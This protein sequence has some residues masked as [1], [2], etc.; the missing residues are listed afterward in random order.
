MVFRTR[1]VEMPKTIPEYSNSLVSE[2]KNPGMNILNGH[3]AILFVLLILR[4][5][6]AL[7]SND[8]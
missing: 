4:I 6:L 1:H 3:K 5:P 8:T 7:S 2:E